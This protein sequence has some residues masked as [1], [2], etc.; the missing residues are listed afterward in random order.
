M[1]TNVYIDGYNLFYG[2][3]KHSND[4]WL[5]LYHLFAKR[6]IHGQ[7]PNAIV[8]TVYFFTAD[9][10]SKVSTMGANAQQAQHAY[11]RALQ[12]KVP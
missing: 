5:D 12:K 1:K 8:D 11:H 6:I 4:K 2:C 10:K 3:L 9:I 7:D